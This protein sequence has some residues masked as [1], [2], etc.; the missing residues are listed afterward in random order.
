MSIWARRLKDPDVKIRGAAL[1]E[2]EILGDAAM[3]P[4]LSEVYAADPDPTLR[5]LA[6]K[7][8]Q[9]IY[10]N[11]HHQRESLPE[12]SASDEERQRAAE[13]LAMAERKRQE[14]LQGDKK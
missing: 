7:I 11:Q 6:Q 1:H 5:K 2:V 4:L 8:G 14:R 3:L 12:S 9:E 13:I 10:Y